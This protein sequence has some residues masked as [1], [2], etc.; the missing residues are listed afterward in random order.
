MKAHE[1]D[2]VFVYYITANE[3]C[4]WKKTKN[5]VYLLIVDPIYM[6][7]LLALSRFFQ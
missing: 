3:S 4:S 2:Y 5:M 7:H 1:Y 6:C